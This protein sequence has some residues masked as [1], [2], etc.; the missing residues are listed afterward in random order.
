M[1]TFRN[2]GSLL[3]CLISICCTLSVGFRAEEDPEWRKLFEVCEGRGKHHRCHSNPW[4]ALLVGNVLLVATAMMINGYRSHYVFLAAVT[5]L[6]SSGVIT[7]EQALLGFSS[8]GNIAF[9][10]VLL[11]VAG[12]QDSGVLDHIFSRMLGTGEKHLKAFLRVQVVTALLGAMV[13][14]TTVVVAAAPALQ[15]WAPRAGWAP[16]EVLL[17]VSTVAAMSQNLV[18]VTSTVALTIYQTMPEADLQMLDPAPIC[19]CLTFLTILYALILARPLLR[20]NLETREVDNREHMLLQSHNRYYLSFEVAKGSFLIDTTIE[21][22]GL[23]SMPGASLVHTDFAMAEPMAAG[24]RL[25]FAAT[26]A[27]VAQL[28]NR[29]PGLLLGLD[30]L[31]VLGAQRHRRRLFEVGVAPGSSL[32][33]CKLPI[34]LNQ[35]TCLAA[36]RPQ[37]H[38][39]ASPG[40]ARRPYQRRRGGEVV[41]PRFFEPTV[42]QHLIGEF[43]EAL[44]APW[45]LGMR[46]FSRLKVGDILL[47]EAF[48][49]FPDLPEVEPLF[50]FV[51]LV[52]ESAP[53]RHGRAVDQRRGWLA[54]LLLA[55]VILLALAERGEL[56]F[57]GLAAVGLCVVLNVVHRELLLQRLNLPIFL[58]IA[59]GL[60]VGQARKSRSLNLISYDFLLFLIHLIRFFE[61]RSLGKSASSSCFG[62]VKS[63][64]RGHQGEWAGELLGEAHGFLRTS[65]F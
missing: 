7:T 44:E 65:S 35:A 18:V 48:L 17:P 12:I 34:I 11:L 50:S 6:G 59:G 32:I 33:G 42:E 36:R 60:G 39:M 47:V 1:R 55:A 26:A 22:A 2:S 29:S 14:Q 52:P 13:Q 19:L 9:Q 5:F 21:Q 10:A 58:T 56:V 43:R 8:P 40:F 25:T 37:A 61:S 49:E 30:P 57:L 28:R 20:T 46:P 53:P 38:N 51:A 4:Q 64:L 24:H 15:R 16:R 27:G 3:L 62:H 54:L 23:L 31:A 63:L 45:H 41:E